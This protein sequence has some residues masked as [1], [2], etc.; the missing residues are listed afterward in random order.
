MVSNICDRLLYNCDWLV[1]LESKKQISL[2]HTYI[3]KVQ[4]KL[5]QHIPPPF[6]IT[7][8]KKRKVCDLFHAC[9]YLKE[10]IQGKMVKETWK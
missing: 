10:E 5:V 3:Y 9:L 1:T 8:Q 6:Q 4:N 2:W 7:L